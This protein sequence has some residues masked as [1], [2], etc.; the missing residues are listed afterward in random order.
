VH[1]NGMVTDRCSNYVVNLIHFV[2][3]SYHQQMHQ[4]F[5]NE[6]IFKIFIT[7]KILYI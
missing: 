4:L 3:N 6:T 7:S 2:L 5:A 1:F